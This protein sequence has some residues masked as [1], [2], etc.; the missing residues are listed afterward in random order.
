MKKIWSNN[1]INEIVFYIHHLQKSVLFFET[2]SCSCYPGWSAVA[3]SQLTATS[4]FRVQVILLP[5]PPS[6]RNYKHAPPPLA[7]FFVFL[8][9]MGF[10]HVGQ[11]DLK[12]L[13]SGKPPASASQSAGITGVSHRAWLTLLSALVFSI[14]NHFVFFFALT[15]SLSR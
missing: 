13:T 6:S 5:L 2:E 9:E 12:L 4:A 8:I 7:N 14:F 11:T 10:H 15:C 3:R 1:Q